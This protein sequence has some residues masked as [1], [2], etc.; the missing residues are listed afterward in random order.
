MVRFNVEKKDTEGEAGEDVPAEEAKVKDEKLSLVTI[1]HLAAFGDRFVCGHVRVIDEDV[2]CHRVGI[3]LYDAGNPEK[4]CPKEEVDRLKKTCNENGA[5]VFGAVEKI[6]DLHRLDANDGKECR[7][8]AEGNETGEK[9]ADAGG[10]ENADEN[11]A[12]EKHTDGGAPVAGKRS[13]RGLFHLCS[14]HRLKNL[15]IS[16]L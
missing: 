16:S 8:E 15:L 6:F 3:A 10:G 11:V 1:H 2:V 14:C 5:E 4:Q 7:A 9:T 13:F 12:D